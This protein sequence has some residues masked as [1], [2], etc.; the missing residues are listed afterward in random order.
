VDALPQEVNVKRLAIIVL[1]IGLLLVLSSLSGCASLYETL[2]ARL[3]PSPAG[4]VPTQTSAPLPAVTGE[5]TQ[6]AALPETCA[7]V[8]SSRTLPEVSTEV[9]Q[10]FRKQ[11]LAEV[12]VEVSAY[13]ENC[14]EPN[15]NQVVRFSA[16][17]TD[18][19][20]NIALDSVEDHQLLGE[21]IEKSMLVL[22]EYP[23][24]KVPGPNYGMLGITFVSGS[25]PVNL[26]FPIT[27]CK[28]LLEEGL[29]GSDLF[30]ALNGA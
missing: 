13:G 7:F 5:I 3:T 23:P 28:N 6:T 4:Y 25:A 17:Q 12:E 11:G 24:G 8:W 22:N 15:T 10:A 29:R 9:N 27:K 14:L 26:S 30:D 2:A 20:L 16:L 1:G 21:W 19:F 18:F